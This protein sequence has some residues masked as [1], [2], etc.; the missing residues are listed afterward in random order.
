MIDVT[1][2]DTKIL[3]YLASTGYL[4]EIIDKN[5]VYVYASGTYEAISP[6]DII[7]KKVNEVY[8]YN[9]DHNKSVL[10]K[11]LFLARPIKNALYEYKS[12]T[13]KQ[14]YDVMD[15]TPI[16]SNGEVWGVISIAKPFK[17]IRGAIDRISRIHQADISVINTNKQSNNAH[18]VF[19]DI[20]CGSPRMQL[21]INEAKKIAIRPASV[22]IY[23]ETGTGKELFAQ[24]IH[25]YS[26]YADGPFVA[27]NCSAIP[28]TLLEGTLFGTSK[29]SFTDAV[30]KKGLLED[31]QN[32]TI[33]LDEINSMNF[34]LQSKLLR[35][36]DEKKI[37]RVGS[38]NEININAR[39]ISAMNI[40]PTECFKNKIMRPDLF[41]RLA[42]TTIEIPPLRERKEDIPVLCDS[43]I[44]NNNL[45]YNK[46]INK[47]STDV[48]TLFNQYEWT[49]NVREL[50]HIIEHSMNM[51]DDDEYVITKAH[52]PN[53]FLNQTN[54]ASDIS[55]KKDTG[56]GKNFKEVRAIALKEYEM[57]FTKY[58]VSSALVTC[59]GNIKKTADYLGISRQYLYQLIA[60][61]NISVGSFK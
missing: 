48:L 16:I 19:E 61:K 46:N 51:V 24:S 27:V 6:K 44:N 35:A 57:K 15:S 14:Y 7:G 58:V 33:F 8:N 26:S 29:G 4:I 28:D 1:N 54:S 11:T 5:G 3:D 9:R 2:F 32:G 49:G 47:I 22:L 56:L 50:Q 31:A 40:T 17:S 30:E 55:N 36:L 18:Y 10:L 12:S 37:R 38:N 53:Y 25:N 43:F 60:D 20:L 41:Y 59:N 42:V 23:G 13:G 34:A 45:A 21:I 52:L 39:I